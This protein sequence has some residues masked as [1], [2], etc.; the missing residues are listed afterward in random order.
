MSIKATTKLATK[1]KSA[2]S[3]QRAL[4]LAWHVLQ[5]H[6]LP[7]ECFLCS[8]HAGTSLLCAPCLSGLPQLPPGRCV[9][10][11]LPLNTKPG[12]TN[13]HCG[14]C[15]SHPPAFD[16]TL[17]CYPYTFPIDRLIHSFKYQHQL[18][19]SSFLSLEMLKTYPQHDDHTLIIPMPISSQRLKERGFNQALELARPLARRLGVPLIAHGIHK[20]L[21]TSP[22]AS[23]PWKERQKNICGAFE[24]QLD[25]TGKSIIVVDDVMTTGATL[26]E[27]AKTLKTHGASHISNWVAARTLKDRN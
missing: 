27:L 26:N 24:C 13:T 14:A 7:Q 17:A 4:G 9:V 6:L 3:F 16:A 15:L 12:A 19:L 10:C 8:R 25:L 2:R 23:L 18:A 5:Q 11:A 21:H 1:F 20:T 22:Q